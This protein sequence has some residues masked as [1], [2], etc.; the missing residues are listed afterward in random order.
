MFS[1]FRCLYIFLTIFEGGIPQAT[2]KY[3]SSILE[4]MLM[5]ET[6]EILK[7]TFLGWKELQE[8]LFLLKV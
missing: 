6:E 2:P 8:A 7:K 5:E 3:N 1:I 4:D